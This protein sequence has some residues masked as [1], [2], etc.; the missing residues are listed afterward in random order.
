MHELEEQK[1]AA[2]GKIEHLIWLRK[3]KGNGEENPNL[4]ASVAQCGPVATVATR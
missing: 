3:K 1:R 2:M 4:E